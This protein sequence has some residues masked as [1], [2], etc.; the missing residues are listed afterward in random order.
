MGRE[1]IDYKNI[2][3]N[4]GELESPENYLKNLGE[5]KSNLEILLSKVPETDPEKA[6]KVM[7]VLKPVNAMIKTIEDGELPTQ[8][9][10]QYMNFLNKFEELQK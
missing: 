5:L 2:G 10:D 3:K 1:I 9:M 7:E 4:E 8:P 6:F